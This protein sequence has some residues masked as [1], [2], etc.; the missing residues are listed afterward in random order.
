MSFMCTSYMQLYIHISTFSIY[1]QNKRYAYF[2]WCTVH[3]DRAGN[4]L[5]HCR[6]ISSLS[7]IIKNFLILYPYM[8]IQEINTIAIIMLV[9]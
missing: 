7:S 5:S 8:Y 2:I 3:I 1:Y 4:K 9:N 6:H